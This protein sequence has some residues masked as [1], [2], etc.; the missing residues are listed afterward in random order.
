VIFEE[1]IMRK[2]VLAAFACL[3]IGA[4]PLPQAGAGAAVECKL[5][6]ADAQKAVDTLNITRSSGEDPASDGG[7]TQYFNPAGVSVLGQPASLYTRSE[8]I[9]DGVHRMIYRAEVRSAYPD[10]RAAMLKLHSKASCDAHE[11]TEPGKLGCMVHVREEGSDPSSDVDMVI[12]EHEGA[13]TVGCIFSH[14]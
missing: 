5:N 11:S 13:V 9:S 2:P 1:A 10:A 3:L 6:Y 14:K 8:F 12:F 4:A 7:V